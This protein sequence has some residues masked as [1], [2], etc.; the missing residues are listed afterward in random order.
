[1]GVLV[2]SGCPGF[3]IRA[4]LFAFPTESAPVVG[5]QVTVNADKREGVEDRIQLFIERA[6]IT[7]PVPECDLVVKGVLEG[8]AR[9]WMMDDQGQFLSDRSGE[10][11]F[12]LDQLMEVALIPGQALTFTCVPWGSGTRMGIDRNLDGILDGDE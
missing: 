2:F 4:Y 3:L 6:L 12:T 7:N 9:G 11:P 10:Q 1:M 5:Q 8:S